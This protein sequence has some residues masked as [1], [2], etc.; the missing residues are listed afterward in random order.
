ML[1]A[2][3]SFFTNP[4]WVSYK[5][6]KK[7]QNR[8]PEERHQLS[9]VCAS[10]IQSKRDQRQKNIANNGLYLSIGLCLSLV[11][12]IGL[13]EWKTYGENEMVELGQVTSEFEEIIDM[14]ATHQPPPPPPAAQ[15]ANILEV[16]DIVE[17]EEELEVDLDVEITEET[18][19]EEVVY[20]EIAVE[21]EVAEEIFQFVEQQP[22]PR[23]GMTAFYD[24]V[25]ENLRYPAAAVRGGIQGKVYL[26][27]VV[28]KQGNIGDIQVLKG[29]GF[30]C[31]EEAIRVLKASP[32]WSPGKQRGKPVKVRMSVPIHFILKK[33]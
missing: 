1:S 29:I 27:F 25:K 11:M 31:D 10:L 23:G 5:R 6:K 24:F 9:E 13:F 16:P 28:D 2:Q 32:K 7:P 19:I 14:P 12:V 15:L 17:I 3:S 4:L 22:E 18:T 33:R 30:G 26:Q 8:S 20:T 21:E